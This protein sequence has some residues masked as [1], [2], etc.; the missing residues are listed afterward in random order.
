MN[1][2]C[3]I[4]QWKKL[5]GNFRCFVSAAKAIYNGNPLTFKHFM[6]LLEKVVE[7]N[8]EDPRVKLTWLIK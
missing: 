5:N 2:R 8:I 1:R 4:W 6:T 3:E 7:I